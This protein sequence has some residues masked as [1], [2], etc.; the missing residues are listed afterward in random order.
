MAD[1]PSKTSGTAVS[2]IMNQARGLIDFKQK[3]VKT[4][5][6]RSFGS[7]ELISKEL[8]SKILQQATRPEFNRQET[9]SSPMNHVM[10]MMS[11]SFTK[12]GQERVENRRILEL[13]PEVRKAARLMVAS[14]FSPGDLSRHE[15]SVKFEREGLDPEL[16][17]KLGK[18]ATEFF[19]NKLNLKT[20][21][22]KWVYQYGYETGASVFAIIP[23]HTFE[24]LQEE[25]FAATESLIAKDIC[26]P[27][28][29][30]NLFGFGDGSGNTVQ[31]QKGME[32][33]S[34]TL[35][36]DTLKAKKTDSDS[37]LPVEKLKEASNKFLHMILAT[38]ALSLTDNPSILQVN[39]ANE[40]RRKRNVSKKLAG[41][42]KMPLHQP[43]VDV[44]EANDGKKVEGNPLLFNLPPES[45]TVIHTPGDPAD[46]QGYLV[47]LDITGNPV[48][49]VTQDSDEQETNARFKNRSDDLFSSIHQ[50]YGIGTTS[51]KALDRQTMEHIYSK[52]I[53]RH[54]TQ[55]LDKAGFNGVEIPNIE[56]MMRCL[57]ARTMREKRTRVLFLPREL[58]TYMTFE[59]DQFGYGVS[60]LNGI[61]FSLGMKMAL[62]VARV[63]AAIKAAMDKRLLT[64]KFSPE[65]VDQPE[66]LMENLIQQYIQKTAM[67]FSTDPGFIQSQIQQKSFT[68]KAEGIPGLEDFSVSNEADTKSGATDFDPTMM[69]D[70]NKQ[71]INGLDVPAST[72][73]SL[74][75]DEYARS[76]TTTNLFFAMEVS[77]YQDMTIKSVT[78]L[79]RKYARY[80]EEFQKELLRIIPNLMSKKKSKSSNASTDDTSTAT[81]DKDSD[82]T[83]PADCDFDDLLES[84]MISLPKPNIAPSKAHFESLDSMVSSI[85][86]MMTALFPDDLAGSDDKLRAT[87]QMLRARFAAVNIREYLENAGM[88]SVDIP[89]IN[90]LS[91]QMEDLDDLTNNLMNLH[92]MIENKIKI[93]DEAENPGGDAGASGMDGSAPADGIPGY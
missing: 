89:E 16:A 29:Q 43:F 50:A 64:M 11:G 1:K 53:T 74:N 48:S 67:T 68:V 63:L 81:S 10:S 80:S 59:Y 49:V 20:Q 72:M 61:K 13:M 76:V 52:V 6:P 19:Q 42:F 15:I 27:L 83:L 66:A 73:N 71:I 2:N 82:V 12:G 36:T 58:V 56:P 4:E 75:E 92:A 8:R 14:I 62:Q 40:N 22:P 34:Q 90:N 60:K 44:D 93:R 70:L 88:S 9:R 87:I 28:C 57:F 24:K 54:L 33:F 32:S 30:E 47:L 23:A 91:T 85:T 79:I 78:D 26:D 84:M 25:T 38:E 39:T 31:E 17:T 3:P 86:T 7:S 65:M 35:L 69:D 41:K 46:H 45:I 18:F 5:A 55:R 37:E 51:R 77:I 21:A